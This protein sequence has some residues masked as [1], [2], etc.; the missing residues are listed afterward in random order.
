MLCR[1]R[2]QENS[3][4]GQR[5]RWKRHL[6]KFVVAV[7]ALGAPYSLVSAKYSA[8]TEPV[9]VFAAASLSPAL[10]ILGAQFTTRTGIALTFSYAASSQLARQ[11]ESGA[12]ADMFISADEAWMDYLEHRDLIQGTTRHDVVGNR[13]VLV[14][15]TGSNT[16]LAVGPR[17]PLAQ[18]LGQERLAMGDPTVVPLGRYAKA[19]LIS[20]GVWE[21]VAD[22][23]LPA[24]NARTALMYVERGEAPLGV[25]YASDAHA[26]KGVRVV[27]VFPKDSH[28][29]I[30]YPM[31]LT[32]H[33]N[34]HTTRWLNYLLGA[35]ANA[36]FQKQGFTAP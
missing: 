26:S 2:Q 1:I 30:R 8:K 34:P 7:L 23:I 19:A 17:F 10:Q 36:V 9:I 12:S 27:A 6:L 22:R 29:V 35:E 14:A 32:S 15:P 20:L 16:A 13:L 24:D 25:V 18:A 5:A 3:S 11:I 28:P 31:A 4:M 33:A 21:Q